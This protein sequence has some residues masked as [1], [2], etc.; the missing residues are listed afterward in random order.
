MAMRVPVSAYAEAFLDWKR[1]KTVSLEIADP[2]VEMIAHFLNPGSTLETLYFHPGDPWVT[3][4]AQ[5]GVGADGVTMGYFEVIKWIKDTSGTMPKAFGQH[6]Y[7]TGLLPD[8]NKPSL[9]YANAP[10][11]PLPPNWI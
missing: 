1:V 2:S 5:V 8:D 7:T 9:K 4:Y 3:G 6:I 10:T 11:E